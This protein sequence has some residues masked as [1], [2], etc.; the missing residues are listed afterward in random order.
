MADP[1][2]RVL[3]SYNGEIYN[4]T[5]LRAELARTTGWSFRSRTDTEVILAG[6][7]AWGEALLDRIEGMYA[8]AL[9]DGR[10]DE[11][12]LARDP[13]GIKPLFFAEHSGTVVFASEVKGVLPGLGFRP[14]WVAERLHAYMAQGYV[15]PSETLFDGISQVP[16]GTVIIF[17]DG[18]RT[19]RR[20]WQPARRPEIRSLDRAVDEFAAV[21]KAVLPSHL[22]SDVPVGIIQSGGIDSS[23]ITLALRD[24]APLV[25]TAGFSEPSHDETDLARLVARSAG[26]EPRLITVDGERDTEKTFRAITRAA[27]GQLAD[28]SLYAAYLLF[29]EVRRHVKV[30]LAGDGADEFFAGYET[31][32]A[33]RAARHWGWLFPRSF[34]GLMGKILA[35]MGGSDESRLSPRHRLSRF[36]LGLGAGGEPHCQWRRILPSFLVADMYGPALR[37]LIGSDPLV[38]YAAAIAKAGGRTDGDL[39]GDQ[40]YYLPADMLRK[41]D[42]ASMAHGLEIRVPFLS[43]PVMDLA[44]RID[45]RVLFPTGGP[46]KMPLRRVATRLGAPNAVASA[47][48]RGFNLPLDRMLRGTLASLGGRLLDRE[49]DALSPW[50][51]PDAVRRRWREHRDR[52]GSWGYVLWA[53]LTLAVWREENP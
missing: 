9:W 20:Y 36:L 17:R 10:R 38:G 1:S 23:L 25:F 27:D 47:P 24:A 37:G 48:K 2:G 16:P 41:V 52:R 21:W 14:G 19:Q 29:A 45:A 12:V 49:A 4:D 18:A 30:G 5:A 39:L 11:L 31:Y 8:F 33:S 6:W 44:G 13:V 15:G 3:I 40:E 51:N 43:R 7:M 35:E 34:A 53:L 32:R 22:V 50:F 42:A 26:V 46:S 28:S